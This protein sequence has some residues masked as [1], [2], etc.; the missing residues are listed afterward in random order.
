M[1]TVEERV[2]M[3]LAKANS[4]RDAK[5]YEFKECF[6]IHSETKK[7][8]GGSSGG[9]IWRDDRLLAYCFGEQ[10]AQK[11]VPFISGAEIV[12]KTKQLNICQ[13]QWRLFHSSDREMTIEEHRHLVAYS[14]EANKTE[15]EI[16]LFEEKL[17][18]ELFLQKEKLCMSEEAI[19]TVHPMLGYLREKELTIF[20]KP[21]VEKNGQK[22]DEV[23][24]SK[25]KQC[26]ALFLL[27]EK[28]F[29]TFPIRLNH[30]GWVDRKKLLK[31]IQEKEKRQR[32]ASTE[33]T[34]ADEKTTMIELV[35]EKNV[36]QFQSHVHKFMGWPKDFCVRKGTYE[37]FQNGQLRFILPG[38]FMRK[39]ISMTTFSWPKK[40]FSWCDF[41]TKLKS[42]KRKLKKRENEN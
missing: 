29:P 3:L 28:D 36:A 41:C 11:M 16:F 33:V 10:G 9:P 6:I 5:K 23:F 37:I 39:V 1:K 42:V 40:D 38:H 8:F 13:L 22:A 15:D 34:F 31:G 21:G 4:I 18:D 32:A 7:F 25:D 30:G 12:C 20:F 19:R 14:T 26:E 35:T 27:A 24:L 17:K 2:E